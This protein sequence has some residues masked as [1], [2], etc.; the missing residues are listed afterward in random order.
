MPKSK[1]LSTNGAAPKKCTGSRTDLGKPHIDS[2]PAPRPA[3][4]PHKTKVLQVDKVRDALAVAQ[5][6]S[7]SVVPPGTDPNCQEL[8]VESA[9]ALYHDFGA[10]DAMG[11]ILARVT[12]GLGNMTMDCLARAMR[13]DSLA[14]RQV[15][16][17]FATKGALVCADLAR[18]YDGRRGGGKQTV[19]VGRVNVEPGGQAVVGNVTSPS[20]QE[21]EHGAPPK[22]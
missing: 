6:Y 1:Q 14:T 2:V 13:C 15:E 20:R 18:A 5:V 10:A 19:T 22:E 8:L 4:G 21:I 16:L 17:T 9:A 3:S 11:S 12:V 7:L